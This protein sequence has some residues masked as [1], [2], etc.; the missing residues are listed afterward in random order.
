MFTGPL[1]GT[2]CHLRLG[3][4]H[5]GC[6]INRVVPYASKARRGAKLIAVAAATE[7]RPESA[8]GNL[9]R[10]GADRVVSRIL[11]LPSAV[12]R[13]KVIRGER[14]PMRDGVDLLADRFVPTVANDAPTVL[15]RSPYGRGYPFAQFYAGP[16]AARG[17][18]VIVQSIRGTSGSSG[19][20]K[21]AF[22]EADDGHDTVAWLRQQPWFT[23]KLATIG[24][25]Y[26]GMVQWALMQEPPPELAAAVILAAPHAM[27]AVWATGSFTLDDNLRYGDPTR[28]VGNLLLLK[29]RSLFKGSGDDSGDTFSIMPITEAART[30]LG[31]YSPHVEALIA[32][33]DRSDPFWRPQDF[34]GALDRSEVPV[35]L[36]TGWQDTF[37][38]QTLEQYGRL[39]R[40]GVDVALTIGPWVHLRMLR[41]GASTFIPEALDWLTS[42]LFGSVTQRRSAVRIFATGHG[43]I[44]L[45]E[46]PPAMPERV[47]PLQTGGALGGTPSPAAGPPSSFLFDPA[48]PTPTI[49]GPLLNGGGYADDTA[50]ADR[51]DVLSFVSQPLAEDMF[52]VGRPRIELTHS[53]DNAHV[54][55]FVRVSEVTAE[56]Q[57]TNVSEGYRRLS[58]ENPALPNKVAFELDAVAHRFPA[59]SR[60]RVVV[61]GG[62]HP[63]FAR[64]PGTGEPMTTAV[65]LVPVTHFVHHGQGGASRLVLPAGNRPPS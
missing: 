18:H 25:S 41:K 50:L 61:A 65:R 23:G 37:L 39:R 52:V 64:N 63:R 57:S 42:H 2:P 8:V 38:D 34:D 27:S 40:R 26:L 56:G 58:L 4:R 47:L 43:W 60:I 9:I 30:V 48:E 12:N 51:S 14:I 24:P 6:G 44:E 45:P 31:T 28:P 1:S 5:F 22:H 15:I 29:L 16:L 46:W 55:V 11:R 36:V 7:I 62:S 35:L 10:R 17:F 33:P 32:H 19:Q 3:R 49:G 54:D 59:G 13:Y 20:F 21:T 53:A